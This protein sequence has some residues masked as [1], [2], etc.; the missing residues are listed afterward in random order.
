ML[1]TI[2]TKALRF[3]ST[4]AKESGRILVTTSE[5]AKS[6]SSNNKVVVLDA[7][8]HMPTTNRNGYDEYLSKRIPTSKYFD[9]DVISD[10]S[11]SPTNPN[12]LPHQLPSNEVF[13]SETSKLGILQ[14][15]VPIVVYD[16]KGMFS[17]ARCWYML[18]AYGHRTCYLLDGGLPKWEAEGLP[19]ENGEVENTT[20]ATKS[21][22]KIDLF[23]DGNTEG[24]HDARV[25]VELDH[26]VVQTYDQ[27]VE[28]IRNKSS[29]LLDARSKGRFEGTEKEPR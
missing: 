24:I 5:L 12:S 11:G 27:V 29:I 3:S 7:S 9:I 13:R 2:T 25:S 19:L 14:D 17:A 15:D 20:A 18:H 4:W 10:P 6:L 26:D 8:W 23:N 21:E 28:S 16:S 22:P 1:P